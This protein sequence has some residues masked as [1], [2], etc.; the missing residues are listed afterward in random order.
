M[1]TKNYDFKEKLKLLS[2]LKCMQIALLNFHRYQVL[3]LIGIT[4][5]KIILSNLKIILGILDVKF[6]LRKIKK[7]LVS[8]LSN[9]K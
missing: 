9:Q 8:E 7:K 1:Q 5:I 4:E 3:N 2:G 6:E